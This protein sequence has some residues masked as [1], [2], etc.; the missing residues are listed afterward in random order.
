MHACMESHANTRANSMSMRQEHADPRESLAV[1]RAVNSVLGIVD[2]EVGEAGAD[3]VFEQV[4]QWGDEMKDARSRKDWDASDAA[5]Q[6][7]LDAGYE[8]QLV[9]DGSVVIKKS[10]A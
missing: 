1:W 4:Q 2:E 10:L 5:R 8:V 3:P 6:K 9:K 7:I